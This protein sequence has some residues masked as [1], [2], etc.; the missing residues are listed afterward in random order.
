MNAQ[1]RM[2]DD[3]LLAVGTIAEEMGL[4]IHTAHAEH[5]FYLCERHGSSPARLCRLPK[6]TM[7]RCW[8][9]DDGLIDVDPVQCGAHLGAAVVHELAHRLCFCSARFDDLNR[10]HMSA[11]DRSQFQEMV[12]TGVEWL[13]C[14]LQRF[15]EICQ[16]IALRPV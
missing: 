12:A 16:P 7:G 9:D 5:A 2:Y 1:D 15:A 4:T 8:I 6:R 10:P 14:Q 11:Y 13:F 3:V